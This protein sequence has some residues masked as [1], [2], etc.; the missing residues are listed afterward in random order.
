MYNVE[1]HPVPFLEQGIPIVSKIIPS[2]SNMIAVIF[3]GY[4]ENHTCR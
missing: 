2:R 4:H 3:P 1:E